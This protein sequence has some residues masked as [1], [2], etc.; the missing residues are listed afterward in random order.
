[1]ST[2][3]ALVRYLAGTIGPRETTS[4]AHRRA[5]SYVES[6]F[7]SYGYRVS[8]Q[9]FHVPGGVENY[10]AVNEGDTFNIVA[11]PPGFM[12]TKPHLVIGAH[13]DTVPQAPGAVD[14]ATGV[15]I[16]LGLARLSSLHTTRIPVVFDFRQYHTRQDVP[17]VLVEAQAER[18]GDLLWAWLRSTV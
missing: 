13:L 10:R 11:T 5:A 1:M 14:N 18:A 6:R 2:V 4:D 9:S 8:R 15:A 7:R 16:V 12:P 3:A 17:S